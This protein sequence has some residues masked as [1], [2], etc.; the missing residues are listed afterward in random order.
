MPKKEAKNKCKINKKKIKNNN[1]LQKSS[2]TNVIKENYEEIY[3]KLTERFQYYKDKEDIIIKKKFID[4]TYINYKSQYDKIKKDL[5]KNTYNYKLKKELK[6]LDPEKFAVKDKYKPDNMKIITGKIITDEVIIDENSFNL[7]TPIIIIYKEKKFKISGY[8]YVNQF[9][10]TWKCAFYRKINKFNKGKKFCNAKIRGKRNKNK[11]NLFEF[12][13]QIEH[14]KECLNYMN[15]ETNN[16]QNIN[17]KE[18]TKTNKLLNISNNATN[19]KHNYTL[20]EYNDILKKYILD[21]KNKLLTSKKF[22]IFA[23]NFC[24]NNTIDNLKI[25]PTTFHNKYYK[26]LIELFPTN[27]DQIFEYSSKLENKENFCRSITT[28]NLITNNNKEIVHKH[29]LFF[30][31]FDIKRFIASENILIDGT[32]SYPKGYYQTIIIMYLDVIIL[33][34]IP[35]I[36]IVSNNKTYE[37]YKFIF[38]DLLTK[39]NSIMSYNK[40]KLKLVSVTSDFEIAL[41]TAFL[42]VFK[43]ICPNI[44]HI[45]CFY[46]YL[47]NIEKN[48]KKY[49]FGKQCFAKEHND[50]ITYFLQLPFKN[51]IH[52]IIEEDINNYEKTYLDS[53]TKDNNKNKLQSNKENY[54]KYENAAGFFN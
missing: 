20:D 2:S 48:L 21:N 40:S 35:G 22:E 36:F 17:D 41:Y 24:N 15:N 39:L 26:L 4:D 45:G 44:K 19:D 5:N 12:Y 47:A 42:D 50:L 32:F 53:F 11:L 54:I 3:L 10:C 1:L 23:K 52:N 7:N 8:N 37:G 30:S 29:I 16:N 51:N 27:S 18:N 9:L 49:G 6:V 43:S 14:T 34:M 13:L 25:K 33:K 46:H 28:T 31:D 38:L